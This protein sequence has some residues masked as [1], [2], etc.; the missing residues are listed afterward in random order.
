M[1]AFS[2]AYLVQVVTLSLLMAIA[3]GTDSRAHRIPNRL[4]FLGITIALGTTWGWLANGHVVLSGPAWWS[5]L[6]GLAAGFGMLLPLYL[7]RAM[8]AGDVKLMAM[9][10][11]FIGF[12][13]IITATLYTM[14]AGGILALL[15]MLGRGV[16]AQTISNLRLML[17]SLAVRVSTGQ[18]GKLE[19]LETTAA[20][21]PYALAIAIGTGAALLWPLA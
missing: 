20:R 4:L 16:A 6:A 7:F 11:A 1:V 12:P 19:P 15:F 8:G 14:A 18:G 2:N 5:P 21:M 13:A 10:G 9:V 17:T 3:V